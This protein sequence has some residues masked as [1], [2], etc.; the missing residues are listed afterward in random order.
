MPLGSEDIARENIDRMLE[1]SGWSVQY[2]KA[3]NLYAKQGGPP[4]SM[5][6]S[7]SSPMS[8]S[9]AASLCK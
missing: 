3:V 1:L 7:A 2:A 8:C 6:R 9:G 4:S 5:A